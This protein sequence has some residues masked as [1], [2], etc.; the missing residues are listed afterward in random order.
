[1]ERNTLCPCYVADEPDA[2]GHFGK[3]FSMTFNQYGDDPGPAEALLDVS[4]GGREGA[5][6]FRDAGEHIDDPTPP[7]I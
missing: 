7:P 6:A 4:Y 1:M 5:T 2:F 3:G